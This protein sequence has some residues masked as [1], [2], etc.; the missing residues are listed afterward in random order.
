MKIAKILASTAFVLFV[1]FFSS[2]KTPTVTQA[3]PMSPML[4]PLLVT[5]DQESFNNYF[6]GPR[7]VQS[8]NTYATPYGTVKNVGASEVVT[9]PQIR[10]FQNKF[11]SYVRNNICYTQGVSK[12]RI[13]CRVLSSNS[14]TSSGYPALSWMTLGIGNLLGM[15]CNVWYGS[16]GVEIE[17]YRNSGERIAVYR[18]FAKSKK[19]YAAMWWSY[20]NSG[21]ASKTYNQAFNDCMAEIQN[22]LDRD[23]ASLLRDLQ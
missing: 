11:E 18:G 8:S 14:Y 15:P 9:N 13:V 2:C 1:M 6:G 17:I 12:G 4:P 10:K 7:T 22:K 16:V 21:A 23:R 20:S 19:A 5:F 3:P